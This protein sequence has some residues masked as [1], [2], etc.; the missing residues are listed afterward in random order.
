MQEFVLFDNA[1]ETV[2]FNLKGLYWCVSS[3]HS[4]TT[5]YSS[6]NHMCRC[7]LRLFDWKRVSL[8]SKLLADS[9]NFSWHYLCP[10]LCAK[11]H[12]SRND[13]TLTAHT[14]YYASFKLA[15]IVR[16]TSTRGQLR[17]KQ[18]GQQ[19]TWQ[20]RRSGGGGYDNVPV[21]KEAWVKAAL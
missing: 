6:V 9:V 15:W 8:S 2:H 20:Q 7:S 14:C 18:Y 4:L 11:I 10:L 1:R 12:P 19:Q 21:Q 3:L 13:V 5:V 16:H 17:V